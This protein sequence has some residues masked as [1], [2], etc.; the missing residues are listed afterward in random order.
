MVLQYE[1][2]V[3]SGN[4]QVV[5]KDNGASY[6]APQSV[7]ALASNG[8]PN[9]VPAEV[10]PG[11]GLRLSDS[12]PYHP[13]RLLFIGHCGAYVDDVVW[14]SDDNGATYSMASTNFTHMDEAQLVE[15]PSGA[16]IANVRSLAIYSRIQSPRAPPTERCRS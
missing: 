13:G 2:R 10:G 9:K 12:N 8:C 6:G 14:Y 16:V 5:S 7:A 3:P 1:S 15:T 4:Y 11:V